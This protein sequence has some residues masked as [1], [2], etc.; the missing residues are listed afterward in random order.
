MHYMHAVKIKMFTFVRIMLS[1]N[2][3]FVKTSKTLV[4]YVRDLFVNAKQPRESN[5]YLECFPFCV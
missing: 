5:Q 3:I 4:F 1:N 2:N